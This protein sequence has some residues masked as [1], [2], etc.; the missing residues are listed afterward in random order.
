[1]RMKKVAGDRDKAIE[2]QNAA[3]QND[4]EPKALTGS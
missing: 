1:M 2:A 4:G 3:N